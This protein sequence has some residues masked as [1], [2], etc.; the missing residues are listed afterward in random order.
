YL[1]Q[2]R[3]AAHSVDR[4]GFHVGL[5]GAPRHC[6][7]VS[8]TADGA[9]DRRGS[10]GNTERCGRGLRRGLFP[11]HRRGW[12]NGWVMSGIAVGQIIGIPLGTLLAQ[13]FN[14]RWPFL[15]FAVTM[16]GAFVLIW[17]AVPQPPVQLD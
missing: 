9:C 6:R 12:A 1:R 16:G 5:V 13:W 3:T 4:D 14:F 17:R 7:H 10:R 11:Y 2:D 15:V 8:L